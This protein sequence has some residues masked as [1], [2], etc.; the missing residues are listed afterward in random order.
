MRV[1][2]PFQVPLGSGHQRGPSEVPDPADAWPGPLA[3][4]MKHNHFL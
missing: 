3:G 1:A 4:K 2:Y